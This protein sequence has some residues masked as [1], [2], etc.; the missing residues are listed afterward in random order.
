MRTFSSLLLLTILIPAFSPRA[1]AQEETVAP[2]A[3]RQ[4][5]IAPEGPWGQLEFYEVPLEFPTE[6]LTNLTI[7][8]QY[9][10]WIFEAATHEEM[11]SNLLVAGLT[12]AEITATF[13]GCTIIQDE[14]ILRVYPT[15]EA[16]LSMPLATRTKLYRLLSQYNQNRFYHRPVY[17]NRQNLSD[18]FRGSEV[19]RDSIT[20]VAML[21]Y[22]TANGQGFYLSDVAY[23]LR[24]ATTALEE[25]ELLR[26]LLRSSGLIVRLRLSRESLTPGIGEYWTAGYKNKAVMPL[27]ESVVAQNDGSTI[28]I[29]HLIPAL[30]RQ[31]L[32]QFPDTQDGADGRLPDWFWTCYNFFRSSPRAVYADSDERDKLILK[33]FE[34][35][36][37]PN[38]FGDLLLLNSGGR[39][40]HGCIHI[41]ADIVY[42]KNSSDIYSPWIFMRIQ[43]VIGYHDV[44]GDVTISTFRKRT[45]L[46]EAPQ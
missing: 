18:W 40:L 41:A 12:P 24:R 45:P 20:D 14:D 35:A 32:N 11:D 37:P 36:L 34:P 7:P 8:S 19:D 23:T 2:V 27:L 16:V 43:D 42:T 9:V 6:L 22:P 4:V 25:R 46:P 44:L 5:S 28:D 21:A 30:P 17:I 31:Y 13:T 10:E 38:Q 1:G 29:A 33:E 15:D 26:G 3:Q 39:I